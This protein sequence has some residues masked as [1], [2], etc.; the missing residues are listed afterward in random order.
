[1]IRRGIHRGVRKLAAA[2]WS[3]PA[4]ARVYRISHAEVRQIV[5]PRPP[6]HPAQPHAAQAKWVDQWRVEADS[7]YQDDGPVALVELPAPA[8]ELPDQVGTLDRPKLPAIPAAPSAWSGPSSPYAGGARKITPD[9]LT[10]ALELRAAGETWPGIA[11]RFGCHRMAL[12][13]ALRRA[14]RLDEG[15][16]FDPGCCGPVH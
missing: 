12:Y 9:V 14:R 2:G 16:L 5:A 11:R 3:V 4:I 1:M 6:R 7:R 10:R 8:A 13:H 15:A